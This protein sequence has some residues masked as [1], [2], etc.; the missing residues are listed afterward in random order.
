MENRR[1]YAG[2]GSRSAP[3]NIQ[4][5][6]SEL[7]S[8]LCDMG[9]WLRSG[10]ADGSDQ[11]FAKGVHDKKAQIWLPWKDFN[12]TFQVAHPKHT[13]KVIRYDDSDAFKSIDQFHPKPSRLGGQGIKLMARNYRQMIGE[14]EP[15]SEFVICWTTDGNIVGGTGQAW[16]IAL[17]SKIPVYNLHDMS[18]DQVIKE[19]QKLNLLN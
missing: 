19:I 6:M 3:K 11:A 9:Y 17:H 16:R 18:K 2:I 5:I 10:N 1:Y 8:E 4:K 15:D 14:N 7:A 12:F 13:Y